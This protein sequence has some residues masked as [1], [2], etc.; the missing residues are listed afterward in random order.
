MVL[1]KPVSSPA[2]SR[3]RRPTGTDVQLR[4]RHMIQQV[5]GESSQ[6]LLA[7]RPTGRLSGSVIGV[8]PSGSGEKVVQG[9]KCHSLKALM[10]KSCEEPV[11][12]GR[13]RL[14]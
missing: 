7:A 12:A 4:R 10:W 13:N 8:Q 9:S 5:P 14:T 11:Y 6:L 3:W 2:R 1:N